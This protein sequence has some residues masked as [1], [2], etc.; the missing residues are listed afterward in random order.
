V[1]CICVCTDTPP[2]KVGKRTVV[3]VNSSS[4]DGELSLHA[5]AVLAQTKARVFVVNAEA[6]VSRFFKKFGLKQVVLSVIQPFYRDCAHINQ[7]IGAQVRGRCGLC[8]RGAA[9]AHG[10]R[11]PLLLRSHLLR[12]V[13]RPPLR[14][15]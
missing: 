9:R 15:G 7:N 5:Q 1:Q 11:T 14:P 10:L 12:A 6:M 8:G 2:F 13:P 3:V 4:G